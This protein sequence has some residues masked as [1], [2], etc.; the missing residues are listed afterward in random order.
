L[1]ITIHPTR[2]LDRAISY[3]ESCFETVAAIDRAIFDWPRH[4]HRLHNGCAQLGI[5][6][7]D[8]DLTQISTAVDACIS[9]QAR[10]IRI[11]VTPGEACWGIIAAG[12]HPHIY[13][14][15]QPRIARPPA[16]LISMKH[17]QGDRAVCAKFASDYGIM[18]RSGGRAILQQGAMPLL[19]W[20]HH[21][22]C[23]ATANIALHVDG[24]WL[25]P[26]T[27]DGGVLPGVIRHHLLAHS[28]LHSQRCDR[29]LLA[30]CDAIVLLNS[31]ALLQEVA[32]VDGV[33]YNNPQ[34]VRTLRAAFNAVIQNA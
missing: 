34:A 11:T 12:D 15:Q 31:G 6:L 18:L 24:R 30:D 10:M 2:H 32:S 8:D 20:Q 5:A 26:E 28:L 7:N 16:Q 14:Q 9:D 22:C 29:H 13:I 21:L 25:T 23:A 19:W 27:N 3:G 4:L 17:P 1:I 33:A